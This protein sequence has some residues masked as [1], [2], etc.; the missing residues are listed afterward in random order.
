MKDLVFDV[1]GYFV[2]YGS[3]AVVGVGAMTVGVNDAGYTTVLQLPTGTMKTHFEPGWYLKWFG[4]TT[5]YKKQIV[6]DA[7]NDK[8]AS[9]A[10]I[11]QPGI[12]VRYSDGGTGTIYG[13]M[14]YS[15][16]EQREDMLKVHAAFR[17]NNGVA[18]KLLKSVTEEAVNQTAALMKSEEGFDSKRSVFTQ[19]AKAQ[20]KMGLFKTEAQWISETDEVTGKVVSKQIA[21]VKMEKGIPQ[22]YE[23]ELQEYGINLVGFQLN[24]PTFEKKTLDQIAEKRAATMAIITAKANAEKAKQD[25]ITAEAQGKANVMTARYEK[26]VEKER[27]VTDAEKVAQVAVIK[28]KQRVDVAKAAKDEAE[29]FKLKAGEIKLANILEGEGQA[30][31]NRLIIES[32]GALDKKIAAIVKINAAYADAMSQQKWVPEIQMGSNGVSGDSSAAT[33]M[34][35]LLTLQAAKAVNVDMSVQ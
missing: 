24:N 7:D 4:N 18:Y 10:T 19:W 12:S 3:I 31:K 28:A 25:A 9:G 34:I 6:M 29:Q 2:I 22:H 5:I 8:A 35:N 14:R 15:L 17:S 27:A 32:D 26:E 21:V 13:K 16:P 11:D 30:E 1:I 33:D 23:S 20:I